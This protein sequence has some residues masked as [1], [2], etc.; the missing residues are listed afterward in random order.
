MSRSWQ[1]KRLLVLRVV[2]GASSARLPLLRGVP[3]LDG[4]SHPRP[5]SIGILPGA[6]VRVMGDEDWLTKGNVVGHRGNPL[7]RRFRITQTRVL[8]ALEA[9]GALLSA[10]DERGVF[11]AD[12]AAQFDQK[13][14]AFRRPHRRDEEVL[15]RR[16]D[17]TGS[18]DPAIGSVG[19]RERVYCRSLLSSGE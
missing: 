5:D 18:A 13:I 12:F 2:K 11:V 10:I 9:F 3:H 14:L 1:S 16:P 4:R 6:T 15:F 19:S 17:E 8:V 7:T